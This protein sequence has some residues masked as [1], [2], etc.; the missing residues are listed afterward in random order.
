MF[1]RIFHFEQAPL[2][3]IKRH[4][5]LRKQAK[6]FTGYKKLF[7]FE[8]FFYDDYYQAIRLY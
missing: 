8:A 2:D 5:L 6:L 4:K 3:R 1:E 7:A